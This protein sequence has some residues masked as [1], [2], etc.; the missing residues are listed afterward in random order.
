VPALR[1]HVPNEAE[2]LVDGIANACLKNHGEARVPDEAAIA[3]RGA[4]KVL[5]IGWIPEALEK[6]ARIICPRSS[7]CPRR[8]HCDAGRSH[9]REITDLQAEIVAKINRAK[10]S[11]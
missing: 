9:A 3:I 6:P 5:N 11:A 7:A 1:S 10:S 2:R 8:E 4:A